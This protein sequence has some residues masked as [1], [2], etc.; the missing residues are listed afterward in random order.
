MEISKDVVVRILANG[1]RFTN[2]TTKLGENLESA[3]G[4]ELD[5]T[6]KAT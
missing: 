5:S 1:D 3:L 6:N 2:E 4:L